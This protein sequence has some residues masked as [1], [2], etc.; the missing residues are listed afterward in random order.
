MPKARDVMTQA[1]VAC[2]PA[3]TLA[4]AARLM[5]DHNIG[6]VL[7]MDDDD[8]VGII[9]DRDITVQA[10]AGG[11]DPQH[12]LVQD[13]MQTDVVTGDANWKLDRVTETMSKHQ[14]RRLPIVEKGRVVGIVSLG[15][16]A[17]RQHDR[18]AI[19]E[20]LHQISEPAML[21]K[22]RTTE[23]S[24]KGRILAGLF[25]GTILTVLL[26]PKRGRQLVRELMSIWRQL[27]PASSTR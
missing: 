26:S 14:I 8:L 7:V 12:A 10:T 24:N 27:I 4:E 11:H 15:D 25:A 17:L 2:P 18:S 19:A 13:Y 9:T 23:K 20:S 6:D 3:A 16:I 22:A 21:H 5:R 1:V